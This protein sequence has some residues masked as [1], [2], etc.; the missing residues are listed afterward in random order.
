VLLCKDTIELTLWC[1]AA[2]LA[3]RETSRQGGSRRRWG[4]KQ[5][6]NHGTVCSAFLEVLLLLLLVL[7]QGQAHSS[8]AAAGLHCLPVPC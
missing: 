7:L 2:A 3:R 1:P 8:A 6:D 5:L 4:C